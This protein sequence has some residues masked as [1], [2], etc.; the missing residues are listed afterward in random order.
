MGGAGTYPLAYSGT[1]FCPSVNKI[2]FTS[3]QMQLPAMHLCNDHIHPLGPDILEEAKVKIKT[4]ISEFLS[5]IN[6]LPIRLY[7]GLFPLLLTP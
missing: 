3:V 5:Q 2:Q 1:F 4:L 6:I 7:P